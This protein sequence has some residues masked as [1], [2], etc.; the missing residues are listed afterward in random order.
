MN[1]VSE[2]RSAQ[3]PVDKGYI[4]LR[5][6]QRLK[7]GPREFE[8]SHF[9][10]IIRPGAV[11]ILIFVRDANY[12]RQEGDKKAPTTIWK[13]VINGVSVLEYNVNFLCGT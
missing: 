9:K 2:I 7:A 4:F 13:E 3:Y 6:G 11:S 8:I 5:I 12:V 1:I 10:R